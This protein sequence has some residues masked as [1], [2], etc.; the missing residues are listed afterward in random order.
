MDWKTAIKYLI[1]FFWVSC[2]WLK[3]FIPPLFS[4]GDW[5]QFLW[6]RRDSD[7]A[8][9]TK[10]LVENG[11]QYVKN[12]AGI[13]GTELNLY[14]HIWGKLVSWIC[15]VLVIGLIVLNPDERLI[16]STL[17]IQSIYLKGLYVNLTKNLCH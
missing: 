6:W 10:N 17:R 13:L 2:N 11:K 3:Q 1:I 7:N 12:L 8:E 4:N 14:I 15:W 16:V 9:G 5:L